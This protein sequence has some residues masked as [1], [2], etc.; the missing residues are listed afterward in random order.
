[1]LPHPRHRPVVRTTLALAFGALLCA[2]FGRA[3]AQE[4]D[5]SRYSIRPTFGLGV[6]MFAFLGDI[7]NGHKGYSPLL[8][9]VGYELRAGTPLTP[10][11]DVGLYALHGRLGANERSLT[12]NL[13]FES[14]ITTGGVQFTYNF[15]QLLNPGR[16]VEPYLSIGFEA[17]EFLSK[18]DR[19]DAEGRMYHY[20]SDG[21]IRDRAEN[22]PQAGDA[23]QLQRDY[24]YESDIRELDL[25]GFGKYP[26]L[27]WAVPVGIGARMHLG[28][29]FDLRIGTTMHFTS[30]DLIDGVTQDSREERQG[31]ARMDRFLFSSFS[32]NYGI[33]QRKP[34][35]REGPTLSTEE[36]DLLALADDEDGDGVTDW[37][38]QCPGTPAGVPVDANGCPLDGD[39]DGVPDHLDLEPNTAPGAAVDADGVTLTDDA[40]LKAWLNYKDS[41]NVNLVSSRVESFG[42]RG[43]TTTAAKR[44]AYVVK[45]GE[46]MEGIPEDLIQKI[47]SIPDVRTLEK[48]DTTFYVVGNYDALPEALRRQ[49]ALSGKGIDGRVMAEEDGRLID[50]DEEVRRSGSGLEGASGPASTEAV[51]VR[52]QLGAF[53]NKLAKNIF[54]GIPDLVVIEGEDGLTRYYTGSFTDVN[55]AA[56]HKVDM[57]L[58]GFKGAFLVA[59]KNGKRVSLK[60]AGARLTGPEDL[61]NTPV[62]GIDKSLIR[63]RVQVGTFAGNVPMD[64]MD[65]YI[66]IGNVTPVPSVDAV[67]Y[68]HGDFRT[69]AEAE[70]AKEQLKAK[71]L[72]DAFTVG[73]MG[74]RVISADE[75]DRLMA[76]P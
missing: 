35:D 71:G 42:P 31:N 67:R 62:G 70:A 69:R 36:M 49:L 47:L 76:E 32:L 16:R 64:I 46:H 13:N 39:G 19:L 68:F 61:R 55:P 73:A 25:D 74:D 29:R 65:K 11:L 9:R 60:E 40:L 3:V 1:M 54:T 44:R 4:V 15:H 38:D 53:R 41:A 14:R 45:V 23:V 59:F 21:T 75:A 57:L 58:K 2:P 7:G 20:W 51:V 37:N 72:T 66:E 18:T 63:Y 28:G 52:V 27:T 48:G 8:T 10:W 26:E 12:R 5:S 22:D 17:V 33:G 34:R 56:K 30:T 50:I 43:R 6:G 24:S